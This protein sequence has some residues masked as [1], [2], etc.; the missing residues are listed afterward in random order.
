M[1]RLPCHNRCRS[2][3]GISDRAHLLELTAHLYD[4]EAVFDNIVE[5]LLMP[6]PV[7]CF[8]RDDEVE[9]LLRP[10]SDG[11]QRAEVRNGSW[12]GHSAGVWS[13]MRDEGQGSG[14]GWER[15][16]SS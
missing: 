10:V 3:A 5:L 4:V 2:R 7:I 15:R 11:V 9:D 16:E 8:A 1:L 6:V 13:G 14:K 12:G